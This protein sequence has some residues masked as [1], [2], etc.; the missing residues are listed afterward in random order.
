MAHR[1]LQ[2]AVLATALKNLKKELTAMAGSEKAF[3]GRYQTA[4]LY[5]FQLEF[6]A[7]FLRKSQSVNLEIFER[8][9]LTTKDLEDRLGAF[10]EIDEMIGYCE[11]RGIHLSERQPAAEYFKN[12]RDQSLS[13][14]KLWMKSA[15]WTGDQ[16]A[17]GE[18]A[19]MLE[20]LEDLDDQDLREAAAKKM[21]KVLRELQKNTGE[22]AF[23]PKK[24]SGYVL[25]EVEPKVHE[26][27]REIRKIAMYAGYLTGAFALTD[28]YV[29]DSKSASNTLKFFSP[30]IKT[31]LAKSKFANLPKPAIEK[32]LLIPRPYFLAISKYVSELGYAKDWAQNSERLR[33][34]GL[35]GKIS[36]DQ[37]DPALKNVF[38]RPEPFNS[39][40][41]RTI[42]EI[43]KTQIFRHMADFFAAQAE[44]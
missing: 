5:A 41:A 29:P 3:I 19:K 37:L 34:A 42:V 44:R 4:R 2:A 18:I 7:K 8:L 16:K 1:G 25:K 32:P 39:M 22:G 36:F 21:V 27:R 26:L 10:N 20:R 31:A 30:L 24:G 17:A 12:Q 13:K 28:K 14:L 9:H 43:H 15:G 23:N 35:E 38:G 40:V 33:L 11:K 6:L